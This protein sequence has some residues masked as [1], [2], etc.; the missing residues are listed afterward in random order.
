MTSNFYNRV[1]A[2]VVL[3]LSLL[4]PP[5]LS[6]QTQSR[7]LNI[8]FLQ[9]EYC[10]CQ[11]SEPLEVSL[12]PGPVYIKVRIE[13]WNP[14]KFTG[15]PEWVSFSALGR[16]GASWTEWSESL[17]NISERRIVNGPGK[18]TPEQ[19]QPGDVV[20][21]ESQHQVD[22]AITIRVKISSQRYRD[23]SGA[24]HQTASEHWLNIEAGG[25]A[26]PVSPVQDVDSDSSAAPS[27]I[28]ANLARDQP[29]TQSSRSPWSTA[30]ESRGAVDG[31]KNGSFGFHTNE[32]QSPW[33][34]V[35]LGEVQALT[36]ALIFNRQDCC[37]ERARTLQVLLSD[38][39]VKW[40]IA[41]QND[42]SLSGGSE[43]PLSVNLQGNSARY[44]RLQ[45]T[46]RTWLHL[47]E[48]EVY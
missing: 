13:N 2:S 31:V 1:A 5:A 36:E 19:P 43:N 4:T 8:K 47:D 42:G 34:Q 40:K 16:D 10:E 20:V 35:D 44:V 38:D 9:C 41:F 48:V 37:S 33:W 17:S 18:R 26:F 12:A 22:A 6:G 21:F 29:T 3:A 46:E 7:D 45:L 24:C 15:Y 28:R 30:S 23:G 32:E 27:N 14:T 11:E 39:G 25:S